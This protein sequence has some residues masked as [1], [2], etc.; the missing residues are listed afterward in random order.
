[1]TA[2]HS[3]LA[4]RP[5]AAA[6]YVVLC[7]VVM[8]A[9][10]VSMLVL[11]STPQRALLQENGVLETS[12]AL[13]YLVAIVP[14]LPVFRMVWPFICML[15]LFCMREFDLDKLL[16]TEGLF[17]SRQFVGDTVPWIE[18][19]ISFGLLVLIAVCVWLVIVRG[20]RGLPRRVKEGDG[21][22]LCVGLGVFLAATSK[23]ADGFDR[24]LK[25]FGIEIT[26]SIDL[27][28]LTYEEVAEFG[29]ALSFLVAAFAFYRRYNAA[30][31]PADLEEVAG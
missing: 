17:K 2:G 6:A 26:E 9:L 22:A 29:M 8:G 23:I 21:V 18:R 20:L 7:L 27:A 3:Q 19:L 25:A 24:K 28:A 31:V 1:M 16:F 30:H 13:L 10:F 14:L 15:V 4:A 12:S 11:D 5:G